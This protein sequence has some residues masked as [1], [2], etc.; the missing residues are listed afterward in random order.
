MPIERAMAVPR[1][2]LLAL[3]G[4]GLLAS[5]FLVTRNGSNRS[6]NSDS[7]SA[8]RPA[9]T[10]G[11]TPSRHAKARA[12]RASPAK[13]AKR[14]GHAA[15]P[16]KPARPAPKPAAVK[17]AIDGL[18]NS[19]LGDRV[20]AAAKALGQD[21]AVVFFFTNPGAADDVGTRVAM[22]SLR[23]MRRVKIFDASLDELAAFRPML[24][25]VGI[26]QIPSTVIVR[27]GK[28][29]VLLQGFVDAGTL[30]QNVADALR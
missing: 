7:S 5:V 27:P 24:S 3:V 13:D 12:H 16:A 30:R 25:N 4:L 20:V 28:K 18:G 10:P 19:G 17:P 26:S 9:V 22:K 2:V 23:G 14:S 11:P 15:K 6:V 29:A 1:P 21:K 8:A